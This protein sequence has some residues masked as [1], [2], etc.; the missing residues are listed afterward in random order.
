MIIVVFYMI[1]VTVERS[2]SYGERED[3]WRYMERK[4]GI[5][6]LE[7]KD[8]IEGTVERKIPR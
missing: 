8:L 3:L 1:G 2:A 6:V 7:D 5:K 4:Y